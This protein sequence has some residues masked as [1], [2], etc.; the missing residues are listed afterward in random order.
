M[1]LQVRPYHQTARA[2]ATDDTRRRIVAAFEAALRVQWMDDI[3][4]DQ[5]AAAAGTTRQTVIRLFGG[6]E[7][8]LVAFS[9]NLAKEIAGRR[10][11][12]DRATPLQAAR[13]VIADYE[14]D[15]DFIVRALAQEERHPV[16]KVWL[17]FG[18][19]EH[20]R[21]VSE[22]FAHALPADHTTRQARVTQLVVATDVY[23]WKLLR[24]DF[25]MSVDATEALI[26]G[27][28]S[29]LLTED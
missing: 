22:T 19:A 17:S 26:A 4:L 13:V 15:G 25:Q 14:V 29:K 3:T 7:G 10:A 27:L 23:T 24:R 8:L 18:R 21:W 5:I 1:S 2:A 28:I 16:L 12:P 6:K 20:R 11:L 9:E